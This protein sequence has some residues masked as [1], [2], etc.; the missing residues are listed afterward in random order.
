M[1]KNGVCCNPHAE[2]KEIPAKAHDESIETICDDRMV[3]MLPAGTIV[4]VLK[5]PSADDMRMIDVLW[6]TRALVMFAADLLQRGEDITSKTAK[7]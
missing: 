1:I 5:G 3:V 2:R 4:T 7:A 6:D